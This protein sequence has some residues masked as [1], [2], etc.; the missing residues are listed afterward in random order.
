MSA[1]DIRNQFRLDVKPTRVGARTAVARSLDEA[2]A[3]WE[4]EPTNEVSE[5]YQTSSE[6]ANDRH[7]P[8]RIVCCN[9]PGEL[10]DALL[11]AFSGQEHAHG[12]SL[13]SDL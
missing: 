12:D 7:R 9:L 6:D 1:P 5:K 4:I 3:Q 10:D 11:D 13:A 2:D 8:C